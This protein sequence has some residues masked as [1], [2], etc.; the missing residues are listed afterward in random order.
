MQIKDF[1]IVPS[2]CK[3]LDLVDMISVKMKIDCRIGSLKT[4]YEVDGNLSLIRITNDLSL[5]FYIELKTKDPLLTAYA[6]RVEFEELLN[7]NP[8]ECDLHLDSSYSPVA[9]ELEHA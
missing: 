5:I 8:V 4:E 1:W 6:L 3:Y 7:H 2:G 9:D